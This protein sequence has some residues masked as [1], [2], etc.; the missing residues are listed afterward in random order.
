MTA[1]Y[2]AD[3]R[4]LAE[5]PDHEEAHRRLEQIGQL[6]PELLRR[7]ISCDP[8][9]RDR[10]PA[11]PQL[12]GVYLFTENGEHRYVGRTGNFNRRFGE[13]VAPGS[14]H[15]Q[16]PFAFNIAK[17][18]ARDAGIIVAGTRDEIAVDPDFGSHFRAAKRRVRQMD[19]RFVEIDDAATST[20]FE[21]YAS[22]ALR[23][24]GEFNI[25]DTH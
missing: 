22:I 2:G 15:N 12:A 10:R 3:G 6:M 9:W 14:G 11:V 23:T 17:A 18:A 19:F 8:H 25:F 5:G 21:V 24:E 20:I 7:L 4:G 1:N 16:A 13:H